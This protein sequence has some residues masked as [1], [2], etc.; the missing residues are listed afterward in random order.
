MTIVRDLRT[1][2][3]RNVTG[4]RVTA[5]ILAE[6]DGI[7]AETETVAEKAKSIGLSLERL[8][9]EGSQLRKGD[10]IA[11]FCGNAEQV[12]LAEEIL[13]GLM[14][15]PSGIATCVQRFVRKAGN[16]PQIVSGAWKKMPYT[17]KDP[18][19]RAIVAGGGY[20]RITREPFVYLDKNYVSILGGIRESLEAVADLTDHLKVVQLK[21]RY[22]NIAEEA[23]IAVESGASILFIDTGQPSDAKMVVDE[24]IQ[25]GLRDNVGI[26]L[27]GDIKFEDIDELKLFDIDILDIGRQIVDAPLLDM[28][29][30]VADIKDNVREKH[31][32]DEIRFNE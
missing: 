7:V 21:G 10:E 25:L 2:I 16:R 28:R 1:E 11:R 13:I 3:L 8:L 6:E 15:K 9:N 5:C 4:K 32:D 19:H 20:Y 22:E 23:R 27:G 17:I 18:I 31:S 14:A 26:A 12:V 30:E 29:L 24:L